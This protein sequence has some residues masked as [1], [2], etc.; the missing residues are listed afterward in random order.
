[1]TLG[2]YVGKG[3]ARLRAGWQTVADFIEAAEVPGSPALLSSTQGGL[4]DVTVRQY[5]PM[6]GTV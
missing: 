3:E 6:L 2:H 1:M 4:L 5:E